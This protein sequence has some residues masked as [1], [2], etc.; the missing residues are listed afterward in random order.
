VVVLVGPTAVGKTEVA[1]HLAEALGGEVVSLDS[2]QVYRGMD[3]GTAKPSPEERRR[4]RHFLIDIADPDQTLALPTI[5]E[6]ATAAVQDIL[7]RARLPFLVGGTGQYVR[8]VTQ[9]WR[10]PDVAPD[11]AY[12]AELE[13]IAAEQGPGALQALLARVDPLSAERIDPR[14]VRRVVRALE[15]C[16]ATSRPFSQLQA[17]RPPPYRF[18]WIGLTRPRESLYARID[19]RVEDMLARGL[20]REVRQLVAAGYHF[21]LPSMSGLGYGEWREC[22]EATTSATEVARRIRK[23]TR[24]L[25]RAQGAWFPAHDPRIHWFDLDVTPVAHVMAWLTD[26]LAAPATSGPV[27]PP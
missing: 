6:A 18:V 17:R 7:S 25:V 2:R 4:V 15:V 24:R 11:R 3:I 16:R 5:Q 19:L 14:N 22:L 26:R 23:N 8:A 27:P 1:L 9:G 10:V 13:A 21:G 12:R 20:E